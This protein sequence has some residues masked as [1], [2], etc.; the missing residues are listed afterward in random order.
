MS[1][2]DLNAFL[3]LVRDDEELQRQLRDVDDWWAFSGLVEAL[4]AERGLR[5]AVDDVRAA[6]TDARGAWIARIV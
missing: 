4:A 5:I 1:R 3:A 2:S 6:R